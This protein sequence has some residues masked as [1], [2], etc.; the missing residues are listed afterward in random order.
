MTNIKV[1]RVGRTR[2]FSLSFPYLLDLIQ[3]IKQ[4]EN[5]RF[6]KSNNSWEVHCLDLFDIIKS[7]KGDKDIFFKFNSFEERNEFIKI[8][9]KIFLVK[10]NIRLCIDNKNIQIQQQIIGFTLFKNYMYE[11]IL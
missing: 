2:F 4:Y 6:E 11:L 7:Y 8:K 10:N 5:S 1:K 9:D 3:R